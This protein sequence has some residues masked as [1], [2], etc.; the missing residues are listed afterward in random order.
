[1]GRGSQQSLAILLYYQPLSDA[2]RSRL[3]VIYE[4]NDGFEIARQDLLL[5]GPGEYLGA[6]QSGAP[7]L[8]FADLERDTD[9]VEAARAAAEDLINAKSPVVAKHL[10]R[11]LGSRQ[12]FLKA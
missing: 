2:A 8:R 4:N 10:D 7:L 9:L 6:R 12:F 11:W 1:V 5:R 3:K